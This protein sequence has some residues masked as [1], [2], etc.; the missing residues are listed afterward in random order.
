MNLRPPGGFTTDMMNL[1]G[2]TD[3]YALRAA[4]VAGESPL[5]D[6]RPQPYY[7]AHAGRRR[8]RRYVITDTEL[9]SALG[10]SLAGVESVPAA[11]ADTMG[12]VAYLLRN[13]D[14]AELG[15]AI[16]L[17]QSTEVRAGITSATT[18]RE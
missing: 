4:V 14:L 17:V 1:A 9:V 15:R 7:V 2:E 6:S 3:V 5:R 11:I 16:S 8:E 12:D 13:P 18:L 10:S